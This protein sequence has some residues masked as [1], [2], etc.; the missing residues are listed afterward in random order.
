MEICERLP[1][2]IK[3]D[4]Y[5]GE[6]E[7]YENALYNVFKSL[8]IDN[9]QYFQG[10]PIGIF[11]E[12]MYHGKE[13]T[14]WHII[15]EG[16]SEYNRTPDM[17]RCERIVWVNSFINLLIC[18][19]CGDIYRWKYRHSNRKYRYKLWCKKT[20]FIVILEERSNCFMLITAYIV[21]YGH[22]I[23]KLEKEYTKAEKI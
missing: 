21:K 6:W 14:F 1:S 17:R 5:N 23:S 18:G 7:E 15:S 4:D 16:D 20:N 11:T 10:K 13:K 9:K 12:A 3:L 19:D 2:L 22:T 8:F